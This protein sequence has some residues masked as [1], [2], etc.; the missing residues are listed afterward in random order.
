MGGTMCTVFPA[1]AK[2][3]GK[4]NFKIGWNFYLVYVQSRKWLMQ[5]YLRST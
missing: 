5:W 3:K 1:Q 2:N 4:I